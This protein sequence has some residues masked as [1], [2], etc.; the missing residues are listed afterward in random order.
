MSAPRRIL[1]V[2]N[3]YR[4]PGGEDAVVQAEAELLERHGH[5]VAL[6][7]RDNRE[8]E[9]VGRLEALADTFW[10][11]RAAHEVADLV[12][13]FRPELVHAHN[14][15]A[16]VSGSLYWS[17]ARAGV[18]LV[19]T[20]HNYRL[21]CVQAMFLRDG[22]VCEDC[23]GHVPWRGVTRRCYRG[24]TAQSAA[25]ASSLALHR[26]LGSF[27]AKVA[28]YIALT[29]FSRRK[30]AQGGLPPERIAVKPN[31]ADLAPPPPGERRG[32]LFVGRL[33][34]EKGV[35]TLLGALDRAPQARVDVIG[36]G[37]EER[38]V[39]AHPGVRWLGW[40]SSAEVGARMRA[41][42][43]LVMPSLWYECFPRTLVEAF[44]SG[45]P[46]IAS[47]IGAL[48]E[49]VEHGRT[50]LLFEP[51]SADGLARALA[52]AESNPARMRAM[53][54]HAR[55][56]YEARFSPERNYEQLMAIY[57]DAIGA[58]PRIG[59]AA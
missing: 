23:L 14:T 18:P 1:V 34:P 51:G 29:E 43:V 56:V 6:Y 47:R 59:I 44:G 28:R 26:S 53:G 39:A 27:S 21:L 50:G 55:S 31:F 37:P 7:L 19:Q 58:C 16:R 46:V 36:A 2:H 35:A 49:L 4:Q 57:A 30:F 12:R 11:R 52:W 3:R 33:S 22:R 45:L 24:S 13:R 38:A 10:S 20:L 32:A 25:L 15:F 41:A 48:A 40:R 42:A 5:A 9:N 8:L 17:A 54:G